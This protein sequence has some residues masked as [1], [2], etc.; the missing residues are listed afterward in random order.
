[1]S[2]LYRITTGNKLISF[3]RN[4]LKS[5]QVERYGL[6]KPSFTTVYHRLH[7]TY[8]PYTTV[9]HGFVLRSYIS[10]TVY[11]EIQR[12]YTEHLRS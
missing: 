1:M 9:L 12:P 3:A 10:V 11:G 6:R 7:T 2:I 4:H 8:A 5:S